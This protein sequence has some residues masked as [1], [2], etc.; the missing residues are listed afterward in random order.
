MTF[1]H[2]PH[3]LSFHSDTKHVCCVL[4]LYT[5]DILYSVSEVTVQDNLVPQQGLCAVKRGNVM[6][7][8]ETLSVN[9]GK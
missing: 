1:S 3:T 8:W 2:R 6:C 7:G 9:L 4:L 5:T